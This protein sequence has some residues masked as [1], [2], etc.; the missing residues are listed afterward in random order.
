MMNRWVAICLWLGVM[1]KI[2]AQQP[3]IMVQASEAIKA[4][5]AREL[6]RF[7]P[8]ALDVT[9][10]GKPAN[11][12]KAQA[13]AVLRDFFRAHPPNEFSL[14]H[15]GQ[16]KGGQPFAIGQYKSGSDTYRV[17]LKIRVS[18]NQQLIEEIS[19]VKQ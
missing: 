3:E 19:F 5:S 1:G 10:E 17:W 6:A 11:Y 14:I 13:E 4:G 18:G 2:F 8:A 7:F 16:S 9:L 15:R 12:S